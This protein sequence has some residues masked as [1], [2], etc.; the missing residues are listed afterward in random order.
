MGGSVGLV[1]AVMEYVLM[2]ACSSSA[3]DGLAR[4]MDG[5]GEVPLVEVRMRVL[6]RLG[7]HPLGGARRLSSRK[8]NAMSA[9]GMTSVLSST[10]AVRMEMEP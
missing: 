1:P 10:K 4:R 6:K 3:R 8:K 5:M 7:R 2:A 9:W